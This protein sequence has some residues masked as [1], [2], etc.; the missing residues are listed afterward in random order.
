MRTFKKT[1]SIALSLL[2]VASM[3]L[4]QGTFG[5]SVGATEAD[6]YDPTTSLIYG[7]FSSS[8]RMQ[9]GVWP[10][11]FNSG[12]QDMSMCWLTDGLC[13]VNDGSEIQTFTCA[14]E[15]MVWALGERYDITSFAVWN[16]QWG[17]DI[18]NRI[19]DYEVYVADSIDD[20]MFSS[21]NLLCS[22]TYGESDLDAA[23]QKFSV[24][25]GNLTARTGAFIVLKVIKTDEGNTYFREVGAWGTKAEVQ[26]KAYYEDLMGSSM[27]ADIVRFPEGYS[28][29][30]LINGKA[31]IANNN[32]VADLVN[33]LTD[34]VT[35][36]GE[37]TI[38][39][40]EP[41]GIATVDY[42][43]YLY[44]TY[45]L[46]KIMNVTGAMVAQASTIVDNFEIYVG[47]DSA[48][49]ALYTDANKAYTYV[50]DSN[51]PYDDGYTQQVFFT[52]GNQPMGRYVGFKF[53][54][55]LFCTRLAEV[56]V[57]GKD[58]SS[59]VIER[60]ATDADATTDSIIYGKAPFAAWSDQTPV[61]G[62]V[63]NSWENKG[64]YQGCNN[65]ALLTDG[66]VDTQ[67]AD[68]NTYYG[69]IAYKLDKSYDIESF[70][71]RS[72]YNGVQETAYKVYASDS[73]ADLF[74][75]DNMIYYH[76]YIDGI[77]TM[78]KTAT[79]TDDERVYTNGSLGDVTFKTV[80]NGQHVSFLG[81]EVKKGVNYVGIWLMDTELGSAVPTAPNHGGW[82]CSEYKTFRISEIGFYG[83]E[84]ENNTSDSNELS[85]AYNNMGAAG[86]TNSAAIN[87]DFT[88]E[89][90]LLKVENLTITDADG[91]AVD[92]AEADAKFTNGIASE[93]EREGGLTGWR[94][95]YSLGATTKINGFGY[96]HR[97]NT[98]KESYKVYVAD[99]E[100]ALYTEDSLVFTWVYD[101]GFN[102]LAIAEFVEFASAKGSYVG[103][104]FTDM[105]GGW[106][107]TAEWAVW[108]DIS[109]DVNNDGSENSADVTFLRKLLF[110]WEEGDTI[111]DINGDGKFDIL[112]LVKIKKQFLDTAN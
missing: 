60:A 98:I 90:N 22:Y 103:I 34:G 55:N 70:M 15:Y 35:V 108:G 33:P 43:G 112:D 11:G 92:V 9:P 109:F 110:T 54:Y 94:Y 52:T 100:D 76:D 6:P 93:E 96:W 79:T 51:N 3:V 8:S 88:Y 64:Y 78:R 57:F 87:P 62:A 31:P 72:L 16:T 37:W 74:D 42:A 38:Q 41:A 44:L 80:S 27:S 40:V 95:T 104:E 91:N 66:R 106:N 84:S 1:L 45:D 56:L 2:L 21:D 83:S 67:H 85:F 53:N 101:S 65:N 50:H 47:M 12:S 68:I 30:S 75:A 61:R 29:K 24:A 5:L 111:L 63:A 86:Y 58:A 71:L 69:K 26:S 39:Q 25:D 59:A 107:R 4:M 23:C 19:A 81:D 18:A 73:Y 36:S 105:Y 102:P 13:G 17:A 97:H 48:Y 20:N 14:G 46:E 89:N 49:D 10:E 82:D 28:S 99:T 7:K 32:G 77:D